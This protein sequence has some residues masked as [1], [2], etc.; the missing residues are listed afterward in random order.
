MLNHLLAATE[1]PQDRGEHRMYGRASKINQKP[2]VSSANT[3]RP[4]ARSSAA[5]P[6]RAARAPP[7]DSPLPARAA[8][9]RQ[10]SRAT[11]RAPRGAL[12]TVPPPRLL[13]PRRL[14]PRR[15]AAAWR[16]AA[17]CGSRSRPGHSLGWRV[18]PSAGEAVARPTRLLAASP[19][20]P[21]RT[22][23]AHARSSPRGREL[24]AD[25]DNRASSRSKRFPRAGC[26][27]L[28]RDR[29]RVFAGWPA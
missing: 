28:H 6:P 25:A 5:T 13:T 26:A 11:A 22:A 7:Q 29:E 16:R 15:D 21:A 8:R 14:N 2:P 24:G 1:A 12:H 4:S 27:R 17:R 3:L 18:G 19:R 10:R 20:R 23:R 9:T